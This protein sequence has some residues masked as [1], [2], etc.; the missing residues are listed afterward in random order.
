MISNFG[1]KCFFFITGVQENV[2]LHIGKQGWNHMG[3]LHRLV[4]NKGQGQTN[5][6][7]ASRDFEMMSFILYCTG[8]KRRDDELDQA[9]NG[10]KTGLERAQDNRLIGKIEDLLR[11]LANLLIS[12][13][14][15]FS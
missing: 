7:D 3:P 13:L 4:G 5:K 11:E 10:G 9:S 1:L 8:N 6:W 14:V 12:F 2:R 15:L